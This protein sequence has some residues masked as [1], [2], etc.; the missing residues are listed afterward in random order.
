MSPTQMKAQHPCSSTPVSTTYGL[1][2]GPS[3][4][5][6]YAT[7]VVGTSASKDAIVV[8]D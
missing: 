4:G 1:P 6:L 3:M 2:L 5:N 8:S 7:P